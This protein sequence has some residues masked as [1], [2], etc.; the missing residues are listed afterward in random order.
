[1]IVLLKFNMTQAISV[2]SEQKRKRVYQISCLKE[3]SKKRCPSS[4]SQDPECQTSS[5]DD[6]SS[7][8]KIHH[9]CYCKQ[10]HH[11]MMD[12]LQSVHPNEPEVAKAL[13]F[14]KSSQERKQLLNLLQT[15]GNILHNTNVVQS[16][17]QDSK[18]FGTFASGCSFDDR[19]YCIYC[20]GLFNKK[21]FASHLEQCKG[22]STRSAEASC[23][24]MLSNAG[25]IPPNPT[26]I[27][28]SSPE[29]IDANIEPSGFHCLNTLYE[30]NF[31]NEQGSSSLPDLSCYEQTDISSP[32]EEFRNNRQAEGAILQFRRSPENEVGYELKSGNSPNPSIGHESTDYKNEGVTFPKCDVDQERAMRLTSDT[33][34]IGPHPEYDVLR[35]DDPCDDFS[36]PQNAQTV[37]N[38]T[39]KSSVKAQTYAT[40]KKRRRKRRSR[41]H[42]QSLLMDDDLLGEGEMS[43]SKQHV[44]Q[45]CKATFGSP[46]TL[47]RHEYTHTGERPFWCHQCNMGFIQKYRL[48]KH[49]FACHGDTPD[50]EK[51]KR[52]KRSIK[53]EETSVRDEASI[54]PSTKS[55]EDLLNSV[56]V[57]DTRQD[58]EVREFHWEKAEHSTVKDYDTDC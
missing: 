10:P 51:L 18:P 41:V 52:A 38:D 11:R 31:K 57:A 45:H 37:C 44:C 2:T 3:E 20:L 55:L 4:H 48:L 39:P 50:Q 21:S 49:T 56:T 5:T 40:G 24:E 27:T 16:S 33:S 42:N 1:M 29:E 28:P 13:T 7:V 47:R 36:P 6:N 54:E 9:C 19:V 26:L 23:G 12:H 34:S 22:K 30:A 8:F 17:K 53:D 43:N 32:N 15:R 58:T 46:Y 25:P 35:N 14:D